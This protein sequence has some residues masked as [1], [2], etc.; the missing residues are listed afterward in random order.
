MLKVIVIILLLFKVIPI[1]LDQAQL[2][3]LHHPNNQRIFLSQVNGMVKM[4][5][6]FGLP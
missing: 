1:I 5:F 2:S 3:L 4:L 6:E